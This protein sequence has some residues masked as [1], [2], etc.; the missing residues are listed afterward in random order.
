VRFFTNW[1]ALCFGSSESRVTAQDLLRDS[2]SITLGDRDENGDV[3]SQEGTNMKKLIAK[4]ALLLATTLV[5][6]MSAHAVEWTWTWTGGDTG[7]G[8]LTTD[9]L[10]AGSYLITAMTGTWNGENITSLLPVGTEVEPT[11]KID[12]LLFLGSQLTFN[13]LGFSTVVS[14]VAANVNLFLDSSYT[15][16]NSFY[17]K[18]YTYGVFTAIQVPEPGTYALTLAGLGL[19]GAAAKRRKAR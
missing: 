1:R 17:G 2:F 6:P 11:Y 8:T 3:D 13:G 15:A 9:D 7:S 18:P 10:L 14:T 4:T 12:N 16:F 19:A 5:S